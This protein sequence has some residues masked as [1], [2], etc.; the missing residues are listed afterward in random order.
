M[1]SSSTTC[2]GRFW[3]SSGRFQNIHGGTQKFRE[4][5]KN[6]LKYLYKFETLV[7]FEVLLMRLDAAISAPLS[8]LEHCQN[9]QRKCCQGPPANR[10]RPL[11]AFPLGAVLGLLNPVAG[12]VLRRG[13][14]FQTYTSTLNKF[15]NNSGNFWFP[16]VYSGK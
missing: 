1:H 2:F 8:I 5:L 13:L 15:F 11:T 14:K 6:Y 9:L 10:W 12:G 3:P 16:H 4:L 7:P